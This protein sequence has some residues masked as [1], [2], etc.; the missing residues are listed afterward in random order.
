MRGDI[1]GG[2]FDI[3]FYCNVIS[4]EEAD[5]DGLDAYIVRGVVGNE[6]DEQEVMDEQA[7]FYLFGVPYRENPGPEEGLADYLKAVV[8]TVEWNE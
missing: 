5:I 4:T 8:K 2:I 7:P 3:K 1:F 6:T